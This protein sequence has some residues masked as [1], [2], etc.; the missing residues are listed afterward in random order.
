ME[1]EMGKIFYPQK[2][3]LISIEQP[4]FEN[5]DKDPNVVAE[6]KYNGTRLILQ[7]FGYPPKDW[8]LDKLKPITERFE[9]WNREG[10]QLKYT[11]SE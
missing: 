4:L 5:L 11:P 10:S 3:T 2:P 1:S 8:E 7:R 6:I 9:F